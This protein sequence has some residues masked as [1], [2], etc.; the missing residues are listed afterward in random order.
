MERE[1]RKLMRV[2]AEKLCTLCNNRMAG[3]KEAL[4]TVNRG[5]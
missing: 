3:H 5:G 4:R 2:S 1:V